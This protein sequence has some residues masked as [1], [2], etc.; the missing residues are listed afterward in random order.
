MLLSWKA[1]I[2]EVVNMY[3]ISCEN[4]KKN[5]Q[6]LIDMALG[7]EDLVNIVS[8]QGNVILLNETNYKNIM[9]T[10]E[11]CKNQKFKDSLL[12]NMNN[13]EDFVDESDVEW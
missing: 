7:D 2:S 5:L 3:T 12:D 13:L 6:N 11:V 10:L 1:K 4:A 9:L 8:D